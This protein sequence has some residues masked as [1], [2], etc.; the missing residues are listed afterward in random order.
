[1]IGYA[2]TFVICA[3]SAF[4]SP[5]TG[6]S[7]SELTFSITGPYAPSTL[8]VFFFEQPVRIASTKIPAQSPRWRFMEG[9]YSFLGDTAVTGETLAGTGNS[10]NPAAEGS[11]APRACNGPPIP[12]AWPGTGPASRCAAGRPGPT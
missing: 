11:R 4:T 8:R 5:R 2:R 1:M 12:A 9:K 7:R 10:V 6:G 3:V